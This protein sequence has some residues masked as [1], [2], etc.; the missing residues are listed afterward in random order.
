MLLMS[1]SR[2]KEEDRIT[3]EELQRD[4]CVDLLSDL[5][6]VI[7]PEDGDE[8]KEALKELSAP[9]KVKAKTIEK[10]LQWALIEKYS[11]DLSIKKQLLNLIQLHYLQHAGG[12]TIPI[13]EFVL[14][15]SQVP[16]LAI[17]VGRACFAIL[18]RA[19]VI[20]LPLPPG[21]VGY[22]SMQVF[23]GSDYF[24]KIL[25]ALSYQCFIEP[26]SSRARQ[27]LSTITG[28]KYVNTDENAINKWVEIINWLLK[29][30]Q[31][32]DALRI[33]LL[34]SESG[35]YLEEGKNAYQ[36]CMNL[37]LSSFRGVIDFYR[38]KNKSL[39]S[40]H[41]LLVTLL[42]RQ[43]NPEIQLFAAKAILIAV[44]RSYFI[45]FV[46][47]ESNYPYTELVNVFFH[48]LR[49]QLEGSCLEIIPWVA[50]SLCYFNIT[51]SVDPQQLVAYAEYILQPQY[52]SWKQAA[53]LGLGSLLRDFR[54]VLSQKAI[55]RIAALCL[56]PNTMN[57]Y[58]KAEA[59]AILH[60][61][62]DYTDSPLPEEIIAQCLNFYNDQEIRSSDELLF[63]E[64]LL[65][66]IGKNF[67]KQEMV[68]SLP[69]TLLD[70][71]LGYFDVPE[72]RG[73]AFDI[74]FI[75]AHV[76]GEALK[77]IAFSKFFS[78]LRDC[79]RSDDRELKDFV[80][81]ALNKLESLQSE[82][83]EILEII[84]QTRLLEPYHRVEPLTLEELENVFQVTIENAS[85][86]GKINL[87]KQQL[88]LLNA[89]LQHNTFITEPVLDFVL[90]QCKAPAL[91]SLV[92]QACFSLLLKT[93]WVNL[94]ASSD[95]SIKARAVSFWGRED[96]SN[97]LDRLHKCA[98]DA[99]KSRMEGI[100]ALVTKKSQI[101][102]LVERFNYA[103]KYPRFDHAIKIILPLAELALRSDEAKAAYQTCSDNY[104][105]S[106]E[107]MIEI[108]RAKKTPI[109]IH[110]LLMTLFEHDN[111]KIRIFAA[112]VI[113]IG[114]HRS[115]L[116]THVDHQTDYSFR[117]LRYLIGETLLKKLTDPSLE[118]R[119]WVAA[120][121]CHLFVGK[122]VDPQLLVSY[123]EEILKTNNVMMEKIVILG[124]GWFIAD[125]EAVLSA[126][127]L[128]KV[129]SYCQKPDLLNAYAKTCALHLL[130]WQVRRSGLALSPEMIEQCISFSNNSAMNPEDKAAVVKALLMLV[131]TSFE[132]QEGPLFLSAATHDAILAYF[133]M[134]DVRDR[135]YY[136]YMELIKVSTNKLGIKLSSKL[137]SKLRDC[138]RKN[139]PE[140][141][142]FVVTH[143]KRITTTHPE[144]NEI[145]AII[146][147][148]N[149][150]L[151]LL[152]K[153]V[154]SVRPSNEK[155]LNALLAELK[156]LNANQ[157][158]VLALLE[159]HTLEI[160]LAAV[161]A[162]YKADSGFQSAGKP[163]E[164]WTVG[165]CQHW[166]NA[167]KQ[168]KAQA[169]AKDFQ[170][171][172]IAVMMR[173]SAL[174]SGHTPRNTQ[175]LVLLLILTLD[176]NGCLLEV[177][178]SEGKTLITAMFAAMKA[179]QYDYV[180]VV[181]SSSILAKREPRET[182]HFYAALSLT[183]AH[184]IDGKDHD[185][186]GARPCYS[187]NVIYGDTN[188]YQWD[189]VRE[190]MGE[191][192]TRGD[193]PFRVLFFDEADSLL[194]DRAERG[195]MINSKYPGMEYI[196]HLIV[197]LWHMAVRMSQSIKK[198]N[199]GWVYQPPHGGRAVRF[200]EPHHF[201]AKV[202]KTYI[203]K[204]IN[205]NASPVLVSKSVKNFV[206]LEAEELANAASWAYYCYQLNR[207]YVIT[208]NDKWDGESHNEIAPVDVCLTGEIQKHTRWTYLHPF[209]E[210]KHGLRMG[211]PQLMGN[212]LSTPGLC[213]LY[214]N[215]IYGVTGTLGGSDTQALLKEM[216]DVDLVIIPTY[217]PKCFVEYEGIVAPNKGMWLGVILHQVKQEV[218]KN[219]PVLVVARTISEVALLE[220]E[221]IKANFCRKITRYSRNDTEE[222][223]IPEH[224]ME[225]GEVIVA[226]LLAGRGIDWHFP[227]NQD[228][229]IEEAGG[230][231]ILVT[232]LP[233][234]L[235]VEQQI[236]GRTARRGNRGTAQIIVNREDVRDVVSKED[237]NYLNDMKNLKIWRDDV[238]AKRVNNIRVKCIRLALLKDDL[239]TRF[240]SFIRSQPT[241]EL[242]KCRTDS[243]EEQW[244]FWLQ[245]VFSRLE[246][247][248]N[249]DTTFQLIETKFQ[250]FMVSVSND[251]EIVRKNTGLQIQYGNLLNFGTEKTKMDFPAAMDVFTK[252]I[253]D[254]PIVG[255]QAYYN[256]AQTHI[257]TK[258]ENYKEAA[259]SDL[260]MAKKNLEKHIIPQL[261]SM[262]VVHNLNPWTKDG[263][264]NDFAKQT[265]TKIELLKLEV[266]NIDQNINVIEDS[267]K[268]ARKKKLKVN[269]E[270]TGYQDLRE[271]FTS[272]DQ[273][274]HSE[275]NDLTSS[276]LLHL[277][278]LEPFFT[279]KKRSSFGSICVAF[280]GIVQIAVGTLLS[281]SMP[282]IGSAL[283]QE[284]IN[285]L[286]YAARSAL[287]GNFSWDD[288]LARKVGSVAIT[289]ITMGLDVLQES[290]DLEIAAEASKGKKTLENIIKRQLNHK[291]LFE[292]AQK[293]IVTRLIDTGVREVFS[294]AVD[295]L[296]TA[297]M[298]GFSGE[299]KRLIVKRLKENLDT[300][301]ALNAML[302]LQISGTRDGCIM[303]RKLIE[304]S[305]VAAYDKANPIQ[306]VANGIIKGV[307]AGQHKEFGTFLKVADMG[308]ALDKIVQLTDSY[309]QK[310]K[311]KLMY[312]YDQNKAALENVVV[313]QGA[314]A[315]YKNGFY[316]RIAATLTQRIIAVA[317]GE[318]I[319]PAAEMAMSEHYSQISE[320]IKQAALRPVAPE[321]RVPSVSVQSE[322]AQA[323]KS[324]ELSPEPVI[325]RTSLKSELNKL[326][327]EKRHEQLAEAFA[328]TEKIDST[329]TQ[330]K[331]SQGRGEVK[332]PL[333][334]PNRIR[335]FAGAPKSNP[336]SA[337]SKALVLSPSKKSQPV[338]AAPDELLDY[339]GA[340]ASGGY[341]GATNVLSG[342]A[343]ALGHPFETL[344][345]LGHPFETLSAAGKMVYKTAQFLYDA[346]MVSAKST[347]IG[348]MPNL[349][350]PDFNLLQ[351][352]VRKMP[353]IAT[354]PAIRMQA[355]NT[356]V[357]TVIQ[358][359]LNASGPERTE[360]ATEVLMTIFGPGA[361]AKGAIG[362]SN[363][364]QFGIMK[365]PPLFH[366]IGAGNTVIRNNRSLENII[367]PTTPP[368]LVN[369]MAPHERIRLLNRGNGEYIY[370]ITKDNKLLMSDGWMKMPANRDQ[371]LIFAD[372][373]I[374]IPANMN[375]DMMI[376][377]HELAQS[378][379]IYV[380]G[381]FKMVNGELTNITNKAWG[382]LPHGN[383]L[384]KFVE[385]AFMKNGFVEAR[386]KFEP[387]TLSF[388]PA[389]YAK[390]SY[391]GYAN[392][393]KMLTM[394][395]GVTTLTHQA[396]EKRNEQ[397]KERFLA[398]TAAH[399]KS[400]TSEESF[401]IILPED[402]G[403]LAF[404]S[405]MKMPDLKGGLK[406]TPIIPFLLNMNAEIKS[407]DSMTQYYLDFAMM[408]PPMRYLEG[409]SLIGDYSKNNGLH[410]KAI[411]DWSEKLQARD[412]FAD[413]S[414]RAA[415]A[416]VLL[417]E[418]ATG[419]NAVKGY[420][421]AQMKDSIEK[422]N[423]LLKL[424]RMITVLN[425]I[426][427]NDA[428]NDD[429]SLPVLLDKDGE[430]KTVQLYD[431]NRNSDY[432]NRNR[433]FA[434]TNLDLRRA[435]QSTVQ[436]LEDGNNIKANL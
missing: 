292:R 282:M 100:L 327:G 156:T 153:E 368:S 42:R 182:C 259:L 405:R 115:Y 117:E 15:Q 246:D 423:I 31:L 17:P 239:Y 11:S 193:R 74:Y 99:D 394:G 202:L 23:F 121:L 326:R 254:D 263:L 346:E 82:K 354:G 295:K 428:Q 322:A 211:A 347:P 52:A 62:I 365:T 168:D 255:V 296:S 419:F 50:S 178:T 158:K 264:N 275:I 291:E 293:E 433:L 212:Y 194:V 336:G 248:F 159:N 104:I 38:A 173:A 94:P 218:E 154:S 338:K 349:M 143:L 39:S 49:E 273:T 208:D 146:E 435:G 367:T 359:F 384:K 301:P 65:R 335:T 413:E 431:V 410:K 416:L 236:F 379:P 374:K 63:V 142:N 382:Y 214:G 383:H 265:H 306:G 36:E 30:N 13:L 80:I 247:D 136:T 221:L 54:C 200:N 33:L 406:P 334:Q 22:A 141:Q 398:S 130:N 139:D 371:K 165:D 134:P 203:L 75:V 9:L 283:I 10:A 222:N 372:G 96:F 90:H 7:H 311:A 310:F 281:F 103:L 237:V 229:L 339:L 426:R 179:L 219:R 185:G 414:F 184:I 61:Q 102:S 314:I 207:D 324:T 401:P 317:K 70:T 420:T 59:V 1:L 386:G 77:P 430:V 244:T 29:Q 287:S 93:A 140:L 341:K 353:S 215:K 225:A 333:Q 240:R 315:G 251:P 201:V 385:R 272:D 118:V 4:S 318:I 217:K 32:Y 144:I 319:H 137:F 285:D 262:L 388:S 261:Q 3:E 128:S 436:L 250:E 155:D 79:A 412:V 204:L 277:F 370:A 387:A 302:M 131:G 177:K 87:K 289:V 72:A 45:T 28:I 83:D 151:P 274:P 188:E 199:D 230:L 348:P 409:L 299:I 378:Q 233:P 5:L 132:K 27:I 235:R 197:A 6:K 120:S 206:L 297:T 391:P 312:F 92:D 113:L 192:I 395:S 399:R 369:Y 320:S 20:D 223:D 88:S 252:A 66:M 358:K 226:T 43:D 331:Q 224:D 307:L 116:I 112:K 191:K 418:L 16:E 393:P 86:E 429:R 284:G 380:A 305:M 313:D 106:V 172:M 280:L 145:L 266:R 167:V 114:V 47:H 147:H 257:F 278:S 276:G 267:L 95:G 35:K 97:I 355:R 71:I 351:H 78:K 407:H 56:H 332:S 67:S 316:L 425:S 350:D 2:I 304:L 53:I 91:K 417:E 34:L 162:A 288:Y 238:E 196:K 110:R 171:E 234:N 270:V 60:L 397:L 220:Q 51:G 109:P 183:V 163:I 363:F 373:Q 241:D 245:G 57:V 24:S 18:I 101:N 161:R 25:N 107:K 129:I 189:I 190:I 227:K 344:Y 119:Q 249:P 12:I 19:T 294:F 127:T 160:A 213:R 260:K 422:I 164:V 37:L 186:K 404:R 41:H 340:V 126:D 157:P 46:D 360:M 180:D 392:V 415:T 411:Q 76:L 149:N 303:R 328:K 8:R 85:E 48:A 84:R 198:D 58:F 403:G 166:A 424:T 352:L 256:R 389:I 268:R 269:F 133:D 408:Y 152:E 228:A 271:F 377:H 216:Y 321:N 169:L 231:H 105:N 396:T 402:L 325:E 89:Y 434:G 290:A 390:L 279:K 381:K 81:L 286:M 205:D 14:Q 243:I 44:Y 123:A 135:A 21:S 253:N 170:A 122:Q 108:H 175:L 364:R 427:A 330:R 150:A 98:M 69:P 176:A 111:E 343:Y 148:T 55:A 400:A 68:Q 323:E 64:S 258:G 73:L 309:T 432:N 357:E 421:M 124:L 232:S 195:A 181:S 174:D 209:L 361:M 329:L 242:S 362:V 376:S 375:M 138:A 125:Y 300:L 187:A 210:L 337:A 356:V 298:D 342:Y 40:I 308:M 366:N 345:V 26:K